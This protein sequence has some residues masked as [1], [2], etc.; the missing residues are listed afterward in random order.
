VLTLQLEPGAVVGAAE[1]R[2]RMD[3]RLVEVA[4]P[5]DGGTAGAVDEAVQTNGL[6]KK[7]ICE[8]DCWDFREENV[9]KKF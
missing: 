6:K 1:T 2:R 7:D 3:A 5:N 8:A 9:R 4:E